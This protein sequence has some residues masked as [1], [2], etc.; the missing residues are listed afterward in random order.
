[1][2]RPRIL[3]VDDNRAA[4]DLLLMY[5]TQRRY[6]TA[7]A[8]CGLT[9]LALAKVTRPDLVVLNYMMPGMNG[10]AVLKELRADPATA[11]LKVIMTSGHAPV[12]DYAMAAGAQDF[13]AYPVRFT[14]FGAKVDRVLGEAR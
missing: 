6:R 2:P 5:L 12:K 3:V 1:M 13:I 7:W 9:G 8:Y 4:A 10:L 11:G 14:E